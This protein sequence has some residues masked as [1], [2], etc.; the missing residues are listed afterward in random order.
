MDDYIALLASDAN[1]AQGWLVDVCETTEEI[2][3]SIIEVV[4]D[5]EVSQPP[6]RSARLR[7]LYDDEFKSDSEEMNME[8]DFQFGQEDEIPYGLGT[9]CTCVKLLMKSSIC[10]GLL[11]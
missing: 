7:E 11:V 8:I 5:D 1:N 10:V 2:D 6:R 4:E 3:H 9:H